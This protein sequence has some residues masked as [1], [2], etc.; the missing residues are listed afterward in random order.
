MAQADKISIQVI[1]RRLSDASLVYDV[2]IGAPL[3]GTIL[4]PCVTERDAHHLL[5][6]IATAITAH[7][8]ITVDVWA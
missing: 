1:E 3:I 8:N 2:H 6:K 4:L 7:T 5:D